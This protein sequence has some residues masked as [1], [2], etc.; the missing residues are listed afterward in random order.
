AER[1]RDRVGGEREDVREPDLRDAGV[2]AGDGMARGL[3]RDR[4]APEADRRVPARAR[5]ARELQDEARAIAEEDLSAA[6]VAGAREVGRGFERV[7]DAHQVERRIL[8]RA[9]RVDERHLEAERRL[10]DDLP[11]RRAEPER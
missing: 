7:R 1:A 10:L 6:G 9:G 11:A 4:A 5:T 2:V 3:E 8:A